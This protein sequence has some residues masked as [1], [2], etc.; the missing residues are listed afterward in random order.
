MD[1]GLFCCFVFALEGIWMYVIFEM[2]KRRYVKKENVCCSLMKWEKE[3]ED[4]YV[5]LLVV[6]IT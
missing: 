6:I 4:V 3:E 1:V 5:L 2:I